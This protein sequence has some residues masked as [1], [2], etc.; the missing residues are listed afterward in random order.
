MDIFATRLRTVRGDRSQ[1]EICNALGLKQVTY[2]TWEKGKYE[3]NLE[4]LVALAKHFGVSTDWLLGLN[5]DPSGT[6]SEGVAV[7]KLKAARQAFFKVTEAISLLE[8]SL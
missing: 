1:A 2:S 5:N 6:P 7:E 3:P 8:K 4:T